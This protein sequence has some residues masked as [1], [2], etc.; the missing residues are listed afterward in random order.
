M[1]TGQSWWLVSEWQYASRSYTRLLGWSQILKKNLLQSNNFSSTIPTSLWNLNDLL[2]LNL[3]SNSFTGHHPPAVQNFRVITQL[4]LS[5]NQLSG[6]VLSTLSSAQSLVYFSLA[7]NRFQGDILE[8]LGSIMSLEFLDLS[9]NNL[10]GRLPKSVEKLEYMKYFDVSFNRLEGEIPSGGPFLNFTAQSWNNFPPC[11]KETISKSRHEKVL[12]NILP[13]IIFGI[14]VVAVI[15]YLWQR[16]TRQRIG[17]LDRDISLPHPWRKISYQQLLKA[18]DSFSTNSL[19][20]TGSY[21]SVFRG[22]LAD[23]SNIVVKAF[24]LQPEGGNKSFVSECQVLATIRH[25]NIIRILS[26]C[27][28]EHL[29]ALVLEYI[30]NGSLESWL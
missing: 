11:K 25:R 3:S 7:Q 4:D 10:S 5:W 30:P 17:L 23:G 15:I 9:H 2:C 6:D 12:R 21:G 29:K 14:L 16:R 8:S 22:I 18:T 19:L 24:H 13:P 27:S 28:N 26:C 1:P 20:G